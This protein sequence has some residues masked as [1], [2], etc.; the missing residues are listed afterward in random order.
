[1]SQQIEE[2]AKQR[3]HIL[4]QKANVENTLEDIND[5]SSNNE[6]ERLLK[7]AA[8][9]IRKPRLNVIPY[10]VEL[11]RDLYDDE[12]SL[13]DETVDSLAI[14]MPRRL[15]QEVY[16]IIQENNSQ[17]VSGCRVT[18][19]AIGGRSTASEDLSPF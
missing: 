7:K 2:G 1:M 16:K 12:E 15:A 4:R 5:N 14:Y 10:L 6:L 19:L 8:R 3:A 11:R 17:D 13:Q 18:Q 9:N